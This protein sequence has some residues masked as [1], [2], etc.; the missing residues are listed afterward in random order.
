MKVM[1]AISRK[2]LVCAWHIYNEFLWVLLLLQGNDIRFY[3]GKI[4]IFEINTFCVL[5]LFIQ[6]N[7]DFSPLASRHSCE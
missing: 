5:L 2:M 1:V 3:R 6:D 4:L 7:S